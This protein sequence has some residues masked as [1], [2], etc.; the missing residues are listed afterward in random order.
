MSFKEQ[1]RKIKK[2]PGWI[3][4]L[5]AGLLFLYKYCVRREIQDPFH[6]LRD[7]PPPVVTVTWH[8]RILF[9]PLMFPKKHRRQ[10][11]AVVSA[12]RDGQYL[13]DLIH[14]MG[15]GATRGSSKRKAMNALL[16]AIKSL[17][18]KH[19]VAFT[20]DGPRGPCY[21]M[22]VGPIHLA[23]REQVRIIPVAINYTSYWH[24]KSWDGFRIPKPFSKVT[25]ILGEPIAVPPDLDDE[26]LEYWRAFVEQRLKDVSGE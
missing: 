21:H 22:N 3:Y 10:T 14:W 18:T 8:N 2:F 23:S 9:F 13:V 7:C 20:P 1:F 11:E 12:S 15:I 4:A 19:Y 25:L 17:E 24:L 26:K 16:G 6:L 5:P